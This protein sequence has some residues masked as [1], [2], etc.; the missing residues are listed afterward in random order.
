MEIVQHERR[1]LA[2]EA[3]GVKR[4][5]VDL[6]LKP[7]TLVFIYC[8]FDTGE[9]FADL[10]ERLAVAVQPRGPPPDVLEPVV[11]RGETGD[12]GFSELVPDE[13]HIDLRTH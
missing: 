1:L 9:A 6:G 5:R 12:L 13:V 3:V 4:R 7:A 8:R 10:R 2:V 11:A